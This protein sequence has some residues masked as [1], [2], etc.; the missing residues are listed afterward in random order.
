MGTVEWDGKSPLYLTLRNIPKSDSVVK[1]DTI[2]TN[3]YSEFPPGLMLGTVADI[4]EDKS[5]NFYVL[6]IKTAANFFSLQQVHVVEKLYY[7][8]QVAL[9]SDTRKKIEDPKNSKK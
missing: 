4:I 7:N 1:G 3:V 6:K 2:V 8:E 9:L 5:S